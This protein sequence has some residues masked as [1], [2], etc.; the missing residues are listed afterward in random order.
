MRPISSRAALRV[1]LACA[2]VAG[3]ASLAGCGGDSSLNSPLDLTV[4]ASDATTPV[5]VDRPS[6]VS[7]TVSNPGS[8]TVPAVSVVVGGGTGGLLKTASVTCSAQG[9]TCP[10]MNSASAPLFDMPAGSRFTFV[11]SMTA[12]RPVDGDQTAVINVESVVRKGAL[13]ATAHLTAIDGR[14]GLYEL[15]AV[16]GR[17][18]NV[19]VHFRS[20]TSTFSVSTGSVDTTLTTSADDTYGIFPSGGHL[21]SGPDLLVGQADLGA[22]PDSFIAVRNLVTSL[23]DLDGKSFSTFTV[24]KGAAASATDAVSGTSGPLGLWQV[25][26]AGSTLTACTDATGVI[27]TCDPARLRTYAL[28]APAGSPVFTAVDSVHHDTFTF[29]VARSGTSLIYLRADVAPSDALFAIGFDNAAPISDEHDAYGTVNGT[30]GVLSVTGTI[31]EFLDQKPSGEFGPATVMPLAASGS[32]LPGLMQGTR[33]M[34]GAQVVV[35]HQ[36]VLTLTGTLAG[37]FAIAADRIR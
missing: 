29:Q 1:L 12:A 13:G 2:C 3:A 23:A 37:E 6:T 24:V 16:S 19:D 21:A 15:F 10:D 31:W 34:D 18:T 20:G 35:L 32:G 7:F 27:A 22:G 4:T 11:A 8:S 17:R 33:S 30:F 36:G 14:S 25:A 5:D 28:S 9:G 26:I